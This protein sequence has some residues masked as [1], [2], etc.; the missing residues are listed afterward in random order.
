[1]DASL[2][3]LG[4]DAVDAVLLHSPPTAVLGDPAVAEAM[5]AILAGGK[6]RHVG[7]SVDTRAELEAALALPACTLF[8]IPYDLMD[9]LA[10]PVIAARLAERPRYLF[11]REIIR[12]QPQVAPAEAIARALARPDLAGLVIGTRKPAHLQALAAALA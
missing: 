6:A 8:Q 1:L 9:A 5:A 12:L 7:V 3:R 11:G 2:R 10:E 4:L